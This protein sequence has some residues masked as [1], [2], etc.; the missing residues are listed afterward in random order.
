MT[1]SARSRRSTAQPPGQPV[2]RQADRGRRARRSPARARASQRSLVT[3]NDATGTL[4]DRV[5]PGP[6]RRPAPRQV[7]GG[8]GRAGV[9]PQQRRPHDRAGLVEADHAVLLAADGDGGDVVEPAG[10]V[11]AP[12]AAPS[13]Q[14]A[15]STSVPSG[16]GAR[17]CRTSAP[18]SAS[19]ITTLQDWVEESIPA[20]SGIGSLTGRPSRC[21]SGELLQPHEAEAALGG[22]VG[23][24]VLERG[25]GRRAGRRTDSPCVQRRASPARRHPAAASA[26]CDL[27]V[28]PER[29]GPLLEQQVGAH[30]GRRRGPDAVDVLGARAA[31]SRSGAGRRSRGRRRTGRSPAGRPVENALSRSPWPKTRSW[32]Y[33]M[34]RWPL[35]SM[36]KSL[37]CPQRL[38][39]AVRCSSARPSARGRPRG[40][41]PTMSPC[42][43]SAMNASA[44]PRVGSRMSPRGSF[45]LGSMAKRMP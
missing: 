15:G 37:P 34:P 7:G 36:W 40:S 43:S 8:L 29:R 6:P 13:H 20:T 22:L 26:S 14:A 35:R 38:G 27:R 4:P 18:V 9:V 42:S 17:P 32:S 21:S 2:V 12:T 31:C 24:E 30:V 5:G 19:R 11:R 10:L 23:V 16:C 33:L 25:L 44:W 3:V 1:R 45:G 28:G 41:R 39:D